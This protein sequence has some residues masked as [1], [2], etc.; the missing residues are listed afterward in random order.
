MNNYRSPSITSVTAGAD[1]AIL[2]QNAFLRAGIVNEENSRILMEADC[3]ESYTEE[4]LRKYIGAATNE[5]TIVI[6]FSGSA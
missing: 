1:N 3:T 4:A 6:Y 2:V 5:D